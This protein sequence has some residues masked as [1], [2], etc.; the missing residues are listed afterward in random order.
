MKFR[1]VLISLL[2]LVASPV[3]AQQQGVTASFYQGVEDNT[4]GHGWTLRA[5]TLTG[6]GGLA[7]PVPTLQPITSGVPLA[8]DLQPLGSSPTESAGNG[9]TWFDAC[10][11]DVMMNNSAQVLCGR[12]GVMTINGAAAAYF[13]AMPF[14]GA[15]AANM[16]FVTGFSQPR[17]GV[18]Y[19]GNF[20]P[21]TD[22][23]FSLALPTNRATAVYAVNGTIQTS[24]EREKTDIEPTRLGLDYV[25]SLKPVTFR[26][27]SGE[28]HSAHQGLTAQNILAAAHGEPSGVSGE[29][30]LG[31]NY[32]EQ[33][34]PLIKAVQELQAEVE[35]LKKQH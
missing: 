35:A 34:G 6:T 19:N 30:I 4:S 3:H 7:F 33:I 8:L 32:A 9:W 26:W 5:R 29:T 23:T 12:T 14:N 27:R 28:D 15:P 10:N 21:Y 11:A 1:I 17:W 20:L 25:M 31:A 24:D 16:W 18:A 2:A 13:G 22:N